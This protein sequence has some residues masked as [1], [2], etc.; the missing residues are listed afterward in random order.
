MRTI[1]KGFARHLK[2]TYPSRRWACWPASSPSPSSSTWLASSADQWMSIGES[3]FYTARPISRTGPLGWVTSCGSG[4]EPG[5]ITST[6]WNRPTGKSEL[7]K[8]SWLAMG[9]SAAAARAV[10]KQCH[11]SCDNQTTI[12]F[13]WC[14][15]LNPTRSPNYLQWTPTRTCQ[16]LPNF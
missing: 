11:P 9:R 2:F 6:L 4:S 5:A 10:A 8:H 7:L 13:S 15:H 12:H 14:H 1:Y 3:I 16:S